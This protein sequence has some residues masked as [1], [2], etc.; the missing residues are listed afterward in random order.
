MGYFMQGA[1]IL[2]AA[3]GTWPRKAIWKPLVDNCQIV[4]ACDGA[5]VQLLQ[6]DIIPDYV[7]GDLDSIPSEIIESQ[8]KSLDITVIPMLNQNSSDLSKALKYCQNLTAKRIDVI[9][10]E[11]GRLDHQI[12]AYFSLC[13]QNSN[14]ILHL[15][16]WSIRLV[17]EEGLTI[18]SIEKGKNI[19]LF[20][21]GSVEDVNISGVKWPLIMKQLTAGTS[22]LHNESTG[23]KIQVSHSGGDLLL[24]VER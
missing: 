4:I 23:E 20:A 19:S 15:D 24:L 22:G 1:N 12:G 16:E 10:V 2:I 8:I 18:D 17:M 5:I 14:A 3:D 9:G 13:E 21:I 6:N 11:G 7:I